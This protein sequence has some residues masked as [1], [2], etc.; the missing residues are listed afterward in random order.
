MTII[1]ENNVNNYYIIILKN[2]YKLFGKKLQLG[3]NKSMKCDVLIIG[4]G[5]AGLSAGIFACRAGLK[6]ICV[7]KLG[8]GGQAALSYDIANY[9]GFENISGFD[10]TEKMHKHAK[11]LGLEIVYGEVLSLY[12]HNSKFTAKI[13]NNEI[14]ANKVIIA[15]GSKARKLELKNEEKLIG[16]GISFCASCD[17][18]FYKDKVVAVIGGG[19]TA[20]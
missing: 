2:I 10:L 8:V 17:G 11:S 14:E 13:K 6:T 16:R 15:C 1:I 7:E 3:Y 12:K 19:N 4:A 20:I 18:N 5:P 9:P